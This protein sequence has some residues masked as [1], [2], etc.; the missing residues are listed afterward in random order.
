M[1]ARTLLPASQRVK[2]EQTIE[3]APFDEAVGTM[4]LP[5]RMYFHAQKKH[6]RAITMNKRIDNRLLFDCLFMRRD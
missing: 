5:A 3:P 4:F 1:F 6:R 2:R